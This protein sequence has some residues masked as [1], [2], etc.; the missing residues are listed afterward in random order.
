MAGKNNF[1]DFVWQELFMY[2]YA[3]A[4][5]KREGGWEPFALSSVNFLPPAFH[6]PLI[7]NGFGPYLSGLP[8]PFFERR[9]LELSQLA[10]K[11]RLRVKRCFFSFCCVHV[12]MLFSNM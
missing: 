1:A 6:S 2:L 5:L 8:L 12:H 3:R 9:D 7:F 10:R 11:K 4:R